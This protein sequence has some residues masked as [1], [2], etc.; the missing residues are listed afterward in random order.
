MTP[1][2]KPWPRARREERRG[3]AAGRGSDGRA[4]GVAGGGGAW[5]ARGGHRQREGVGACAGGAEMLPARP[6]SCSTLWKSADEADG[7]TGI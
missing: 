3:R 1:G 7:G 4:R 2:R 5:V 6:L